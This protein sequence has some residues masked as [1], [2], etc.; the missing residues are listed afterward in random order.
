MLLES[1][2]VSLCCSCVFLL[3]CVCVKASVV[4]EMLFVVFVF[5]VQS[6]NSSCCS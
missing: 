2:L 3:S 5:V 1:V 4:G 6:F